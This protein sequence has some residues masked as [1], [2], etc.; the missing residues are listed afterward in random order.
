MSGTFL[1]GVAL[2]RLKR[3]AR[4]LARTVEFGALEFTLR[5][6]RH[7]LLV[8]ING[9]SIEVEDLGGPGQTTIQVGFDSEEEAQ[10]LHVGQIIRHGIPPDS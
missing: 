1:P 7:T 5:Y 9:A 6:R 10:R 8:R 3:A 2:P 4:R